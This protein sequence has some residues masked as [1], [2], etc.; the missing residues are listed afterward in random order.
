MVS[1]TVLIIAVIAAGFVTGLIL[2]LLSGRRLHNLQAELKV[3]QSQ[4]TEL[5][6]NQNK[7]S[8]ELKQSQQE[9]TDLVKENSVLTTKLAE[10]EKNLK[11]QIDNLLKAKEQMKQEF[12]NLAQRIFEEKGKTWSEQNKTN[13]DLILNP[14]RQQITDFKAKVEEVY[15]KEGQQ[16]FSLAEEVKKMHTAYESLSQEANKLVLA[17]KSDTKTQ[18]DWGEINLRRILDFTGLKEG[19]H[20]F[21]QSTYKSESGE[22][23]RPDIVVNLPDNRQIIVDSKVSLTGYERY[24]SATEEAD[25]EHGI[26]DHLRSVRKHVLE[27]SEKK[28]E[29]LKGI[30]TLDFVL[31]FI[32]VEAAYFVAINNDLDLYKFASEKK[33]LLVCP[34]TLLITLQLVGSLW[35]IDD[36][37]RN[38]LQLADQGGK[39]YD[40][41]VGFISSMNE[42]KKHLDMSQEAYQKANSQLVDG[43]G[44]LISQ[45]EKLVK[46]GVKYKSRLPEP[47][48]LEA[49]EMDSPPE[50]ED[51]TEEA[52]FDLLESEEDSP[53]PEQ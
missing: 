32:P 2:I 18:G 41:F 30:N 46:L 31:M 21:A 29:D 24:F 44:N 53:V 36:Q 19:I 12:E 39:L 22:N 7:L 9:M 8:A 26:K 35:R 20:Y 27:L 51:Q 38:V 28:Y 45:A 33:V 16:R 15:V 49:E 37:K 11:E 52:D 34:S 5:K 47:L 50:L 1:I 40:K 4:N 14:F 6:E 25:K 48:R 13:L 17:L 43:R 42:I 10:Q 23:L 3:S